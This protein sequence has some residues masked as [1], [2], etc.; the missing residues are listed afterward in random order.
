[1]GGKRFE[2]TLE[3]PTIPVQKII[4]TLTRFIK[5]IKA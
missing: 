5:G 1:M 2:K 3:F 4:E